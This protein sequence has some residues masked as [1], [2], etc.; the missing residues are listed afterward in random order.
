[1]GNVTF[2]P[3]PTYSSDLRQVDVE[4]RWTSGGR[5]RV[6]SM[7]TLFSMNGLQNYV[8]HN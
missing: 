8:F 5:E 4:V 3:A 1:V 7:T 2:S 6:R